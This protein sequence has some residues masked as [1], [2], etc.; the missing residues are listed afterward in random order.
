MPGPDYLALLK[1]F[2]D[3]LR[4]ATYVEI[5]VENGRSLALALAPTRAIGIDPA[6]QIAVN[7]HAQTPLFRLGSDEFFA[8]HDL[9]R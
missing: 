1:K 2:H 9:T 8:R 3:W 4:P 5:G 6:P 7:F